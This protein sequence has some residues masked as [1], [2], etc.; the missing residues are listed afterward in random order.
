[1]VQLT[2]QFGGRPLMKKIQDKAPI[3]EQDNYFQQLEKA[4]PTQASQSII[5]KIL[6]KIKENQKSS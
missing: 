2:S 5:A 3:P 4:T 6:K 1:M